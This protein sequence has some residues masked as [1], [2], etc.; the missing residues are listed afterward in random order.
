MEETDYKKLQKCEINRIKR[1]LKSANVPKLNI[2]MLTPIIENTA[3]MK[4]K[5]DEE[6]A[7]L[8]EEELVVAYNHGGGQSGTKENAHL[9]AYETL[10]KAYIQGMS[11]IMDYLPKAVASVIEKETKKTENVLEMVRSKHKKEA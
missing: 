7:I 4:V 11:K 6:K 9:K 3:M 5:L 2:D 10:W 1:L 8:L